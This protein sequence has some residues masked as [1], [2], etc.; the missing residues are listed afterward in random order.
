MFR[1]FF[2]RLALAASLVVLLALFILLIIGAV[3]PHSSKASGSTVQLSTLHDSRI[4]NQQ[5]GIKSRLH[6]TILQNVSTHPIPFQVASHTVCNPCGSGDLVLNNGSVQLRPKAYLIFWG[7]NWKDSSGNLTKDGQ[8]VEKYFSDVGG[9][10]FENILT[11][12]YMQMPNGSLSYIPNTLQ[13]AATQAWIDTSTPP[14]SHLCVRNTVEDSAIQAEVETA[15]QKNG[16]PQDDPSATFFVYTPPGWAVRFPAPFPFWYEGCSNRSPGFCGY[17][18]TN[19]VSLNRYAAIVF[20]TTNCF[21]TQSPNGNIPGDSLAN[22]TSH[23][24]FEAIT[25]PLPY[26]G[27]ADSSTPTKQEIGDKCAWNFLA[28]YTDLR[29]GGV[30]ELQE[31]YSNATHSCVNTFTPYVY[32]GSADDYVYAV[33]T[34]DHSLRWRFKTGSYVYSSPAVVNGVVYIGS[35]DSSVYALNASNGSLL[36]HYQTGSYI[37]CTPT[38]IN[39]VVYIGSS[40]FYIYALNASNGSLLWHYQTGSY[41]YSSPAVVNGVVY[42]GSSDFYVYALNASNG[43]LIW[44]YQTGGYVRS[45]PAVVNGVVYVDS[46]DGY[47]YAFNASTGSLLWQSHSGGDSRIAPA[48][49]NGVVYTGGAGVAYAFNASTGSLLW[50]Q[51]AGALSEPTV[52]YGVAYVGAQNGISTLNA[53][54]GSLL[55]SYQSGN[56]VYSSPVVAP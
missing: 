18:W 7:P 41:V 42:I 50:Q 48:V 31:E 54:D 28:G 34:T 33:S 11:Q 46:F 2:R 17:H 21:V 23:E 6:P 22:I 29:N 25:D 52:T 3:Y 10:N 37:D 30:F 26:Y 39:G 36:W 55:W 4:S 9:S 49:V 51:V 24:Q 1:A 38:V 45:S 53:T 40:D 27:W 19:P 32:F 13:Y 14:N 16:W 56:N 15:I 20:P 12:Y 5:T 43:S 8:I 44:R 47:L 35:E